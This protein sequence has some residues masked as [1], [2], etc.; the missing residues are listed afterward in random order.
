VGVI[1]NRVPT[2]GFARRI[3]ELRRLPGS[4]IPQTKMD[5]FMQKRIKAFIFILISLIALL[6][7]ILVPVSQAR[8]FFEVSGY[9]FIFTAC[10]LWSITL[11]RKYHQDFIKIVNNHK[12]G[13]LLCVLVTV[14]IFVESPPEYK[15]LADEAN[16]MGTSMM[17]FHNKIA[18]VA[19]QG[20]FYDYGVAQIKYMMGRRPLL[21]PFLASLIHST[22]G[23]SAANGF[24]L[25][26][27]TAVLILFSFYIFISKCFNQTMGIVSILMVA[28][29]PQFMFC[30]TS[31]GFDALNMLFIIL[32]LL[33][34]NRFIKDQSVINAELFLFTTLLLAHCRYESA[35]FL[36]LVATVIP[37]VNRREMV[38]ECSPAI[39]M[40]PLLCVPILWQRRVYADITLL[41]KI[42][43]TSFHTP[44]HPFSLSHF[45]TNYSKNIFVLLGIDPTYGFSWVIGALALAGVYLFFRQRLLNRNH[46][47]RAADPVIIYGIIAFTGLFLLI[48]AYFWGDFTMAVNNRISLVF[49]PFIL[50][51]A[52]YFIHHAIYQ[53]RPASKAIIIVFFIFHLFFF[54][55][56]GIQERLGNTM[57]LKYE[58]QQTLAFMKSNFEHQKHVLV[59]CNQP[60]LYIIQNYNAIDFAYA[61]A[62]IENLRNDAYHDHIIVLQRYNRGVL[63]KGNTLKSSLTLTPLTTLN[64]SNETVLKISELA[65]H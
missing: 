5:A 27:I 3:V 39:Y 21:F 61:N 40:L 11:A 8:K 29:I 41:N 31:S 46:R 9:Y 60:N 59:I 65:P 54:H 2:S 37:F 56:Y 44:D 24:V 55:P 38:F 36:L 33:A 62:N 64:L 10:L 13:L 18:A 26:F 49:L 47:K 22:I 1:V 35:L 20:F 43:P 63:I 53:K 52:L 51:A 23:Y 30:V 58:Y 28:S 4:V 42:S 19:T 17:M 57:M 50:V 45:F 7:G 25:N 32:S 15:V 16:L 48:S 12:L 34:L 6:T 14:L